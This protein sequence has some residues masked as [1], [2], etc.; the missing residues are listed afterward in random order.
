MYCS[1]YS[2][3]GCYRNTSS[4]IICHTPWPPVV[5][6]DVRNGRCTEIVHS[7]EED[8]RKG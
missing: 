2:N 8:D 7:V 1:C 3:T 5:S 4:D 6:R